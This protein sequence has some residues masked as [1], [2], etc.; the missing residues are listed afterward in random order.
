MRT[1]KKKMPPNSILLSMDLSMIWLLGSLGLSSKTFGSAGSDDNA[2]AA[3]VS[4]IRLTH[5]IWVTVSGESTPRKAPTRTSRHAHTLIV[6]WKYMNLLIFRYKERPQRIALLILTNELSRMV[7]SLTSFARAVPSPIERPTWA[8]LSA[9]ASFV[10]SPV[11]ATTSPRFWR[12]PTSLDLSSGR[13]L[14][15]IRRSPITS[16][17][18]SSDIAANCCPDKDLGASPSSNS[19]ISAPTC[20]AVAATSPVTTITFTPARFLQVSIASFTSG[21][22]GSAMPTIPAK[23]R[24]SSTPICWTANPKVLNALC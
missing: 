10:P 24:S 9:N 17:A 7:M 5:S 22:T 1:T 13:A 6:I 16:I 19:P 11:T 8:F 4:M 18:S 14:D 15:R 20:S 21:R 3:N 12:S 23:R 2:M